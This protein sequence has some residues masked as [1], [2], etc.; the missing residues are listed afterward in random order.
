M[1]SRSTSN[2]ERIDVQ[3]MSDAWRQYVEA[4]HNLNRRGVTRSN[5]APETDLTELLVATA[6]NGRVMEN[7]NHPAYDVEAGKFRVQVKSVNKAATNRNGYTVK[8]TDKG[9]REVNGASHYAFVWF[10]DFVPDFV[11]QDPCDPDRQARSSCARHG[12]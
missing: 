5:R 2:T 11:C 7:R 9:L 6:L 4:R 8:Q 1:K 3:T 12:A 10:D